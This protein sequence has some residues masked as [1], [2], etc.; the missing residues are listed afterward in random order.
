MKK[1]FALLLVIMLGVGVSSGFPQDK[2]EN[3]SEHSGSIL[4]GGCDLD[5][6][7]AALSGQ[8][9]FLLGLGGTQ[10][11]FGGQTFSES[12][13]AEE[14]FAVGAILHP[15]TCSAR[16]PEFFLKGAATGA[17][18]EQFVEGVPVGSP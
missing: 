12:F 3:K 15:G 14:L 1:L 4:T 17:D 2:D 5:V 6:S 11:I 10:V 7:D 18:V 13:A 8:P 16:I 9:S